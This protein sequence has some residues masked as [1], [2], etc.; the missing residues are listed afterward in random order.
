MLR[1][2]ATTCFELETTPRK[3]CE[4]SSEMIRITD[5]MSPFEN[6]TP[7]DLSCA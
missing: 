4:V 1:L 5:L 2:P 7:S 3:L 6:L